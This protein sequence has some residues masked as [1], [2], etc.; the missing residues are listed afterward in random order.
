NSIALD[1]LAIILGDGKSSRLY[2]NL[3][4]KPENPVFNIVGAE[5]YQFKDGN[6]FFVQGNFIPDK[7]NEAIEL[8]KNELKE[9]IQNSVSDKE[10]NKAKKKLKV[11]FADEAE[12]VSNIGEI[13]GHYMTVC[14]NICACTEY[15]EILNS[16][17][18]KDLLNTAKHYLV[19]DKA[20]VSILLPE[21]REV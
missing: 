10:F 5:Q 14:E 2:R 11:Q 17:T 18:K 20:T 21:N 1:A 8:V 19:L 16:L 12:T 13:I 6:N 7:K 15:L 3:I 9:I 4:E